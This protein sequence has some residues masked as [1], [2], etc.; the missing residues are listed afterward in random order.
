M[1][2]SFS[3][4]RA[5]RAPHDLSSVPTPGS[6]GE[7]SSST[8]STRA[9]T[10]TSVLAQSTRTEETIVSEQAPSL[11]HAADKTGPPSGDDK[12]GE[13]PSKYGLIG[14]AYDP[15][16]YG[17]GISATSLTFKANQTNKGHDPEARDHGHRTTTSKTANDPGT[18]TYSRTMPPR[19]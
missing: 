7:G 19:D 10:N 1:T 16:H 8:P 5:P 14:W 2:S 9:L 18:A 13:P 3:R 17:I 15:I 11:R 12:Y 6:N 4:R